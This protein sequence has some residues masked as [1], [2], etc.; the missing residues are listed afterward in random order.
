MAGSD[1]LKKCTI[2][3]ISPAHI[4]S[5]TVIITL[6]AV[7]G[8]SRPGRIRIGKGRE[9]NFWFRKSGN[10]ELA[11]SLSLNGLVKAYYQSEPSFTADVSYSVTELS[12]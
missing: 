11:G 8:G 2:P 4:K 10:A 1:Y 6:R 12:R 7:L 3:A 9:L 5:E